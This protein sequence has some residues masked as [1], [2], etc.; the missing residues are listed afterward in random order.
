[1]ELAEEAYLIDLFG[2]HDQVIHRNL[3][4]GSRWRINPSKFY[5]RNNLHN[6]PFSPRHFAISPRK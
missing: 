2:D 1:M 5:M 3:Q 4:A 6:L